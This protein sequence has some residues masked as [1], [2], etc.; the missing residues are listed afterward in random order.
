MSPQRFIRLGNR[1]VSRSGVL[2]RLHPNKCTP[3]IELGRLPIGR[4]RDNN[5]P[6]HPHLDPD[7]E[8]PIPTFKLS[9]QRLEM[10]K[11]LPKPIHREDSCLP[12]WNSVALFFNFSDKPS[13]AGYVDTTVN[14]VR[15]FLDEGTAPCS[16]GISECLCRYWSTLSYNR[17]AF[18]LNSPRG[19]NNDPLLPAVTTPAGGAY[20]WVELIRKCIE[21]NPTAVWEA[22]GSLVQDNKRWIPSIVLVQNYDVGA[23]AGYGGF[24]MSAGNNT[25]VIGDLS[26]IRFGLI[27]CAPPDAPQNQGRIWWGTLNHEY[28]HNFLEF[29]DL[30]SPQ[31]CTGYWDL[32]GDN[33][34]PGRMSEISSPIKARVGWVSYVRVIQGPSL[35]KQHLKLKPYTLTGEAIKII[36]DPTNTPHEYFVLEFRKS[37]GNEV[38]RPD[39]ALPEAGLFIGHIN[40][41][42]G[43]PSTW[44]LRE[45]PFFDPE[46]ADYSDCGTTKWTGHE[47]LKGKLYPSGSKSAFTPQTSPNSNLYGDRRSGVW[48]TDIE[49]QA[50]EVHF[51]LQLKGLQSKVE[52]NVSNSDR[53]IAGHFTADA[54]GQGEELFIRNAHKAALLIHRQ[55]QWMVARR[56]DTWISGWKLDPGDHELVGDFDGDGCDEI[57]IR[58]KGCL[59]LLKWQINGFRTVMQHDLI[60][61]WNLGHV[62]ER[63]GDFDGD[64][65]PEIYFSSSGMAGIIKLVAGY[66]RFLSIQKEWIDQWKLSKDDA[67]YVGAFRNAHTD[68]IAIRSAESLGL[69]QYDTNGGCLRLANLQCDWVDD[70]SLRRD[71]A[72][73]VGDFDGDGLDEIYIRYA[74]RAGMLKWLSGRFRLIWMTQGSIPHESGNPTQFQALTDEDRSYVGRFRPDCDGILHRDVKGVSILLWSGS[75]M[76]VVQRLNSWFDSRWNLSPGDTF[77]L[78]DFHRLGP[79]I[80]NPYVDC[81]VDGITD[82]FIHNGWGTGM[83]GVNPLR[84][85]PQLGLTWIQQGILL[86]DN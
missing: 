22:A 78:G 57:I 73:N 11:A 13:P 62:R 68:E 84:D 85:Y 34:P 49:V 60:E 50:G 52:W 54:Q 86:G 15:E 29:G 77:I 4:L 19:N 21:A 20:D 59:G 35:A 33:S 44:M 80:N 30:Y 3:E 12:Q 71:D 43:I 65:I 40:E 39:G 70:W 16:P 53:V 64:R 74:E 1:I 17:L 56:H 37:T 67:E 31:G 45:A 25:Y 32:L 58:R 38:W 27:K 7:T 23:S 24:E 6:Y 46:F 47:D 55:A 66:P 61:K 41:R 76:K 82:V 81:V 26:H 72:L 18:G 79:D 83:I 28:A 69:L 10:L 63:V 51:D 48:I 75:Q 36:P 8:G 9:D 14:D 5:E 42:L 2:A